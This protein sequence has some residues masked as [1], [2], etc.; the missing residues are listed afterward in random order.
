MCFRLIYYFILF[1]LTLWWF[2]WFVDLSFLAYFSLYCYGG[3]FLGW[4]LLVMDCLS[5]VASGFWISRLFGL[6][7]VVVC[8]ILRGWFVFVISVC[9][10]LCLC[11]P[12]GV[13]V[14][15]MGAGCFV[16][17]V[18][19]CVLLLL[20]VLLFVAFEVFDVEDVYLPMLCG[21]CRLF[22]VVGACLWVC[23]VW[24]WVIAFGLLLFYVFC[25]GCFVWVLLWTLY[26]LF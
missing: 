10:K 4:Y 15:L 2:C 9:F 7:G 24:F 25:L 18:I 23:V 22:S 16:I 12:T 17:W 3:K 11:L 13:V 14:L 26:W 20:Y 21:Y 8:L 6:R 1:G 19:C 5:L